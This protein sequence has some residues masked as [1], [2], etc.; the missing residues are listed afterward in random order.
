[1]LYSSSCS[2]IIPNWVS[3]LH[4]LGV[5]LFLVV[6]FRIGFDTIGLFTVFGNALLIPFA[7]YNIAL[8][9]LL[10]IKL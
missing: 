10:K 1:L 2:K 4:Y 6:Q 7:D 9:D 5:G 8:I 3:I